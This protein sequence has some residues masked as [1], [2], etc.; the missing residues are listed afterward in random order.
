MIQK[1]S[2]VQKT[3]KSWLV[4]QVQRYKESTLCNLLSGMKIEFL[5]P[6]Q[7]ISYRNSERHLTPILPMIIFICINTSEL[8][9]LLKR[10]PYIRCL[11]MPNKYTPLTLSNVQLTKIKSTNFEPQRLIQTINDLKMG[12]K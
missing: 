10:A 7:N 5:L 9:K 11:R 3:D 12:N 1:E 2:F 8:S 4:I 6:M